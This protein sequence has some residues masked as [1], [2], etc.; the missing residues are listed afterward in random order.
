MSRVLLLIF[1]IFTYLLLTL[2]APIPESAG[3]EKKTTH[4]GRGTWFHVGEGNCGKW[5]VDS[6]HIVAVPKSLYD[7]NKGSNCGQ[8][9][10]ITN[11]DTGKTVYGLTRDSCPSCGWGDLDMSPSL[12]EE[13]APLSKGVVNISWNFMA[14]GWNP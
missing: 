12:F 5:N 14:R 9:V 6:D 4:T 3:L 8:Y 10:R 2:A 13:L 7:Q 1:T 11:R